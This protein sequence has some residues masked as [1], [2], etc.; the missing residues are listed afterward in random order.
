MKRTQPSGA[1]NRKKRK[2]RQEEL[3]KNKGSL[4]KYLKNSAIGDACRA[5]APAEAPSSSQLVQEDSTDEESTA[6]LSE[7]VPVV[8]SIE[9]CSA[10]SNSDPEPARGAQQSPIR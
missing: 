1:S 4:L 5:T 8:E 10:D 9:T 3:S 6:P 7:S 2:L